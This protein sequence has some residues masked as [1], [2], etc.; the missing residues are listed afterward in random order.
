[1][2]KRKKYSE[3]TE[4]EKLEDLLCKILDELKDISEHSKKSAMFLESLHMWQTSA[5]AKGR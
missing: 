3:M 2:P 1:M 5:I 4:F